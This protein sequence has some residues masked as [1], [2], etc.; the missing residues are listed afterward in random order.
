M[1]TLPDI[2]RT[3]TTTTRNKVD[4][5]STLFLPLHKVREHGKEYRNNFN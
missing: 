4:E 3:K 1:S 5:N 2:L